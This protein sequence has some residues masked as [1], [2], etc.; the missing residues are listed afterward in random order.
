MPKSTKRKNTL[1]KEATSSIEQQALPKINTGYELELEVQRAQLAEL[2]E[3]DEKLKKKE[4]KLSYNASAQELQTINAG[5]DPDV[6][7]GSTPVMFEEVEGQPDVVDMKYYISVKKRVPVAQVKEKKALLTESVMKL[8]A[9]S[10]KTGLVE[11]FD[12]RLAYGLVDAAIK[13]LTNDG[14][15]RIGEK[16]FKEM[17]QEVNKIT[18]KFSSYCIAEDTD[19]KEKGAAITDM[20]E[21]YVARELLARIFDE[22][23]QRN[24]MYTGGQNLIPAAIHEVDGK[25]CQIAEQVFARPNWI[26]GSPVSEDSLKS[27]TNE[28]LIAKILYD[29]KNVQDLTHHIRTI[30]NSTLKIFDPIQGYIQEFGLASTREM[31]NNLDMMCRDSED[32]N[33]IVKEVTLVLADFMHRAKILDDYFVDRNQ[34]YGESYDVIKAP[35]KAFDP[36]TRVKDVNEIGQIAKDLNETPNL[37]FLL[38]TKLK[39]DELSKSLKERIGTE[40][41]ED[42]RG[43]EN[44]VLALNEEKRLRDEVISQKDAMIRIENEL[45]SN[46][47]HAITDKNILNKCAS[48]IA[49][50]EGDLALASMKVDNLINLITNSSNQYYGVVKEV[51]DSTP[52]LVGDIFDE[53]GQISSP[54]V[55]EIL[56]NIILDKGK[57]EYEVNHEIDKY[58]YKWLS[59]LEKESLI[60]YPDWYARKTT[61]ALEYC[62]MV[63]FGMSRK[64]SIA[65]MTHQKLTGYRNA[66]SIAQIVNLYLDKPAAPQ[67]GRLRTIMHGLAEGSNIVLQFD[68]TPDEDYRGIAKKIE[69][70]DIIKHMMKSDGR[71]N[72]PAIIH[73]FPPTT[74]GYS[75]GLIDQNINLS[76]NGRSNPYPTIRIFTSNKEEGS[77]DHLPQHISSAFENHG[78][79]PKIWGEISYDDGALQYNAF[80]NYCK[81]QGDEETYQILG[82]EYDTIQNDSEIANDN[83]YYKF[84]KLLNSTLKSKEV[85]DVIAKYNDFCSKVYKLTLREWLESLDAR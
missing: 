79:S 22:A 74:E 21:K 55:I 27:L 17:I 49:V 69:Y 23:G 18:G 66:R 56:R 28:Q 5:I 62:S 29:S 40:E 26:I 63:M 80:L 84:K 3:I 48:K 73:C 11:T 13:N 33:R 82:K 75:E 31:V 45:T 16:T 59:G 85:E 35:Y 30:E 42:M 7:F 43:I 20:V 34:N 50:A 32:T 76:I 6:T 57:D 4:I 78:I 39:K 25:F 41:I 8:A 81:S 12:S 72:R 14:E 52:L 77:T 38:I 15:T 83:Y 19:D 37:R 70:I 61:M 58:K 54:A 46:K 60:S 9:N 67:I 36:E 64:A 65:Y 68:N 1:K 44:L 47:N 24:M 10:T 51:I 2:E 53:Y 71:G